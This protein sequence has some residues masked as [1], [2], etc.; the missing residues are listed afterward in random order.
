MK[1]ISI[2]LLAAILTLTA[3]KQEKKQ[4]TE[5]P[6]PELTILEKVA[7]AH[8]FE[9]WENV[10]EIQFT[11]NVERDTSHFER[12]WTWNTVT[13]QVSG[14]SMG[15]NTTYNRKNIDSTNTKIN[16]A[17]INDKFWLL[18]PYQLVWDAHNF[19]HEHTA[20][21][22]APISKKPMQKITIVYG[23][24]GGATPGDAYDFYFEDDYI[25]KEWIFRKGNQTEPSMTTTWEDYVDIEGLK[26]ATSHKKDGENFNLHFTGIVVK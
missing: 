20:V 5:T 18:A 13:N 23:S 14:A 3:C 7:Y 8:G 25:L 17:F 1:K 15:E 21:S 26:I 12:K 6:T 9:A 4:E 11:F 24:Q 10:N 2:L 16:A 19:S 22:V